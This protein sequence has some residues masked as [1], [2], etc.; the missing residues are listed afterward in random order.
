[1][2]CWS[3]QFCWRPRER[4]GSGQIGGIELTRKDSLQQTTHLRPLAGQMRSLQKWG[5]EIMPSLLCLGQVATSLQL[6][7]AKTV[8]RLTDVH[9]G[10]STAKQPGSLNLNLSKRISAGQCPGGLLRGIVGCFSG[11]GSRST[12]TAAADPIPAHW[13]R[14]WLCAVPPTSST[15]WDGAPAAMPN[16]SPFG[17][18]CKSHNLWASLTLI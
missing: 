13:K 3:I 8:I 2:R 5:D 6:L 18:P 16:G 17:W 15:T 10:W 7:V 12:S 1:M 14:P 9:G 4:N 11:D